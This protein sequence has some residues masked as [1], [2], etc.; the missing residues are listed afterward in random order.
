MMDVG[1]TQKM[2]FMIKELTKNGVVTTF[3]DAVGVAGE[4]YPKGM[5]STASTILSESD[6]SVTAVA[7]HPND[8]LLR[9]VERKAEALMKANNTKYD[10]DILRIW[11]HITEL[12]ESMT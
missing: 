5:P 11:T 4:L 2:N 10:G 8:D 1:Q 6:N 9:M 3:D 7:S 12:K